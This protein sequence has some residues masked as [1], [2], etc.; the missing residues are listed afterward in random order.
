MT[1]LIKTKAEA[2]I[3]DSNTKRYTI[4]VKV[5]EKYTNKPVKKGKVVITTKKG[6]LIGEAEVSEN[7]IAEVTSA[8]TKKDYNLIITY[9][10]NY[11]YAE[12]TT[13]LKFKKQYMF[14]KTS[15]YLWALLGIAIIVLIYI[16]ILNTYFLSSISSVINTIAQSSLYLDPSTTIVLS[17]IFKT[18]LNIIGTIVNILIW[19]LIISFIIAGIYAREVNPKYH[20]IIRKNVTN[21]DLFKNYIPIIILILIFVTIVEVVLA[22][23]I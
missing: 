18:N 13:K 1:D 8:I 5:T 4:N 22:Y 9:D 11:K 23:M 3:V 20:T 15:A 12:C 10:A 2:Y 6:R 17:S 14:Y 19:I 21:H 7:G 16:T